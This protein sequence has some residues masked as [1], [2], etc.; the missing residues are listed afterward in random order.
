MQLRKIQTAKEKERKDRNRSIAIGLILVVV[1]ILS[2]LGYAIRQE[3]EQEVVKY[4]SFTFTRNENGW[5][6]EKPFS[7]LTRFNPKEVEEI[8][9]NCK[10]AR[11]DFSNQEVYF[12]AFS[13]D[14]RTAVGE[15]LGNLPIFRAQQACLEG[16]DNRT[17]CA[18]LPLKNCFDDRIIS[19]KV[20]KEE[21]GTFTPRAYQQNRCLFIEANPINITMAADRALFSIYGII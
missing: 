10:M 2:T 5:L 20:I 21:N 15:I 18:D 7:L 1:M 13:S 6:L 8:G 19:I 3:K 4:K 14:E 17:G 16:E 11:E 9:C 12:V